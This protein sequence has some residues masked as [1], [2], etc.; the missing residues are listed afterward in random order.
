MIQKQG[1]WVPHELRERDVEKRAT[2]CNN[3]L[4]RHKRKGFLHRIVTGDEKWIHHDNA[5]QHM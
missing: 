2:M 4:Q 5:N 3:L 1:N